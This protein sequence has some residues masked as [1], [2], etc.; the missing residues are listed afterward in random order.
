MSEVTVE[1]AIAAY[2]QIRDKKEEIQKRH[3]EELAP[4]NEQMQKLEAWLQHQL[5]TQG[6]SNF[7]AKGVG[8]AY[9]QESTSVKVADWDQTLP[10]IIQNKAWDLIEKRVSK[11]AYQD[12]EKE[13]LSPPGVEVRK[14]QSVRVNRKSN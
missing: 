2:I 3:K 10:W 8:V 13:G 9:L 11:T 4:L 12:Y 5:L 1:K 14:E 6:L 7:S